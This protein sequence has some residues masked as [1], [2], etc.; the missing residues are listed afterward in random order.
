MKLRR[1]LLATAMVATGM[2]PGLFLSTPAS[3][4]VLDGSKCDRQVC[5]GFEGSKNGFYASATGFGYW[6]HV[7]LWGPGVS[8]R[9]ST[10]KQD[11]STSA[12]GIGSG[13][14]CA[15]GWE[16]KNGNFNDMG[17]PCV[18]VPS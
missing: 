15:H 13:W 5:V 14:L 18:E 16:E 1:T 12:N 3:A 10:S 17:F 11:P 4:T 6:G 8:F 2:L 9:N 7:D